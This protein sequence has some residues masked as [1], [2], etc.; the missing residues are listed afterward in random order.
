MKGILNAK[1]EDVTVYLGVHDT[2]QIRQNTFVWPTVR[3][4]PS[5]I[6]IVI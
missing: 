2:E 3:V 6:I 1:L 4:K 5:R